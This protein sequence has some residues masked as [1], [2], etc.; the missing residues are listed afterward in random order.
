[1]IENHNVVAITLARGGSKSIPNK[2]LAIINKISLLQRAIECG[3]SPYIDAHYVSSDSDS[4]L[5]HAQ[6]IGSKTIKRPA[7]FSE[8]TSSSSSAINHA[9][10]TLE[11]KP[12]YVV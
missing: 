3:M 10:N 5:E 6:K 9:L 2:N 7:E 11:L 12:Y 1:M 4:I 8:D